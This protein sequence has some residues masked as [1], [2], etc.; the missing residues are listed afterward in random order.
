MT[1]TVKILVCSGNLG[2]QEPDWRSLAA[3]IPDDG[4]CSD[5]LENQK[6]PL[7][8]EFSDFDRLDDIEE[9]DERENKQTKDNIK[10]GAID[11]SEEKLDLIVVGMQESTFEPKDVKILEEIK[12]SIKKEQDLTE[13]AA[14]SS[15]LE[16]EAS[17]TNE[18]DTS[19]IMEED[20]STIIEE[21]A[22]VN[23]VEGTKETKN[24]KL[25]GEE[26]STSKGSKSTHVRVAIKAAK[27]SKKIAIKTN[28][29]AGKAANKANKVGIKAANKAAEFTL[30]ATKKTIGTVNTL[31]ANRDNT[32]N[33]Y[34]AE[35][36]ADGTMVLHRLLQDRLPSYTRL[37]SYQRGEMRLLVYSLNKHHSV[38]VKSVRAPKYWKS[39]TRKQGRHRL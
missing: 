21:A 7:V 34:T 3:W 6:Y 39:G 25:D 19:V 32:K 17:V 15:K 4:C 13:A 10:S 14:S 27:T 11:V 36:L 33:T 35:I 1:K 31:T 8:M 28:K 2:N 29:V 30:E 9:E 18:E 23:N 38:K 12:T 16:Q 37:M 22:S 20:A 5:V 26:P 24:E